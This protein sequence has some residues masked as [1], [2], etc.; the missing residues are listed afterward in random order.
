MDENTP[1]VQDQNSRNQPEH[2]PRT[3]RACCLAPTLALALILI[4]SI[5]AS[6][7]SPVTRKLGGKTAQPTDAA[8]Q[9]LRDAFVEFGK[10][11]F[12]IALKADR[13][14]RVAFDALQA[15]VQGGGTLDQVH[16][17]FR[18]AADANAQAAA[19]LDAL[20]I[21]TSLRSQ[22]KL[23][24]SIDSISQSFAM[25]HDVCMLLVQWNGDTKDQATADRYNSMGEKINKLTEDGLT[26]LGEAAKDNQLTSDDVR[27]FV[28]AEVG[29]SMQ[30]N[31]LPWRQIE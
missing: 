18:K 17:A 30:M 25:R 27:K 16:S 28:P 1:D 13:V 15:K 31:A 4:I 10:K 6:L 14:N 22:D 24:L 26:Y 11:Y 2:S 5:G 29:Q 19:E 3:W 12:A 9:A 7:Y 20:T 21:P 8:T 23:R